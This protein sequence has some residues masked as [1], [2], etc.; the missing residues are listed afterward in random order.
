MAMI[1]MLSLPLFAAQAQDLDLIQEV[2]PSYN[3][4]LK[5]RPVQLG[6]IS[7]SS[8][9]LRMNRVSNEYSL[10]YIYKAYLG[11]TSGSFFED[12]IAKKSADGTQEPG[13]TADDFELKEAD[14][15]G[16]SFVMSQRKYS[17]KNEGKPFGFFHGPVFG[18]RF[19]LFAKDVFEQP[20]QDPNDP[21][22]KYIG[23]LYQNSLDLSYRVGAQFRLVGHLTADAGLSIGARAKY[24]QAK[25]AG[26]LITDNIIG[27]NIMADENSA[28][29]VVPLPQ[30]SFSV[31]YAF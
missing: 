15:Q 28:L 8:E 4:V 23:R 7:I 26:T 11:N 22:Y 27:Y 6:M 17:K 9:K 12:M 3:R 1:V 19:V 2:D 30:L 13:F 14:V 29:T 16:I 31:G 24:A 18:Y 21:D 20:E 25:N 10:G 5:V